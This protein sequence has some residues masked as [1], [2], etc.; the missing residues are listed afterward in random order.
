MQRNALL[1]LPAILLLATGCGGGS[2]SSSTS[3]VAEGPAPAELAGTYSTTLKPADLPSKL[4]PELADG[5]L[6]WTLEIANS[7]GPADGPALTIAS[8][9]QGVLE[10][11]SLGVAG[12]RILLH[13]EECAKPT[14]DALVESEYSWSVDGNALTIDA[15]KNGCPDQIAETILTSE[16]WA[17]K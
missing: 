7:G 16:P 4:P 14:G 12:D 6:K 17:K 11:P 9:T 8:D 2:S 10:S 15:V 3:T 5:G 1:A 13:D